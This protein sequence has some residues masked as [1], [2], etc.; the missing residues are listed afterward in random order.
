MHG[1]ADIMQH[2]HRWY[3]MLEDLQAEES[4]RNKLELD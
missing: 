1:S 2:N 4:Q 3:Q